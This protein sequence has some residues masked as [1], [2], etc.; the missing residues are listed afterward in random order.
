MLNNHEQYSG[1]LIAFAQTDL[2]YEV[3]LVLCGH[4]IY[5]TNCVHHGFHAEGFIG[6]LNTLGTLYVQ[7]RT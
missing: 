2:N 3:G 7:G 4:V 1:C 6:A 5:G